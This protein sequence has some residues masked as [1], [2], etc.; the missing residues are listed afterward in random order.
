[1]RAVRRGNDVPSGTLTDSSGN[2]FE[3]ECDYFEGST[4]PLQP[5][6]VFFAILN[7]IFIVGQCIVLVLAELGWPQAFFVNYLPVLGP[8]YGVGI[9]G[10]MQ[11]L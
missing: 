4:V 10:A 9:L 1:M 7:R 3:I 6:G 11:V 5:G 8:E 2:Q